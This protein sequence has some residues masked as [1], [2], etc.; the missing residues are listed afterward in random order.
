MGQQTEGWLRTTCGMA[1]AHYKWERLQ[2]VEQNVQVI[3]RG[4]SGSFVLSD[5][6]SRRAE[7]TV[8]YHTL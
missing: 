6:C 5:Q 8:P 4:D 7:Q 3:T 2:G 1:D